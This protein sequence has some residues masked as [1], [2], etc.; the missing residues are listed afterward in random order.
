MSNG[1]SAATTFHA[2]KDRPVQLFASLL[3]HLRLSASVVDSKT[4]IR[5]AKRAMISL[6]QL[7]AL[8]GIHT[9]HL[10]QS[11]TSR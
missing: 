9:N 3:G 10:P 4:Q 11:F 5:L 2:F 8:E 6:S 7:F 1:R